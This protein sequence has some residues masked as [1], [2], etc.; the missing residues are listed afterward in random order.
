M[1]MSA[2]T[3]KTKRKPFISPVTETSLTNVTTTSSNQKKGAMAKQEA[4]SEAR[5]VTTFHSMR[6]YTTRNPMIDKTIRL[7]S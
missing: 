5:T 7:E 2:A 3:S 6:T 1:N 4:D